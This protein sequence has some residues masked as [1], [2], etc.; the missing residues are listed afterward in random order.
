MTAQQQISAQQQMIS[1]PRRDNLTFLSLLNSQSSPNS[2]PAYE[3]DHNR[4]AKQLA[5]S[6]HP[7]RSDR[8]PRSTR[9]DSM[10]SGLV[11]TLSGQRATSRIRELSPEDATRAINISRC[12]EHERENGEPACQRARQ[13]RDGRKQFL[14]IALLVLEPAAALSLETAGPSS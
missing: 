14:R 3:G 10:F 9:R 7:P 11:L 5:S 6:R 8:P 12:A 1:I 2:I 4:S 13:R